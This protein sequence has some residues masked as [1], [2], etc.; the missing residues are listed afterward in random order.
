MSKQD[1]LDS[2]NG[3]LNLGSRTS[4]AGGLNNVGGNNLNLKTDVMRVNVAGQEHI[5]RYIIFMLS[6]NQI[7][8]ILCHI[9]EYQIQFLS[10][11]FSDL[12]FNFFNFQ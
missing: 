9:H 4:K 7:E 10:S 12:A 6:L 3:P 11:L 5:L 8:P 2:A 1:S